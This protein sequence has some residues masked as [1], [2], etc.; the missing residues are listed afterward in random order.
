M[1]KETKK[2]EKKAEKKVEKKSKDKGPTLAKIVFL[3][4]EGKKYQLADGSFVDLEDATETEP[5]VYKL[6]DGSL[7]KLVTQF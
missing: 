5:D 7:I 3:P 1:A 6:K 2:A 4:E